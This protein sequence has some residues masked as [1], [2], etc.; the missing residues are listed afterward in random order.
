[1]SK[2]F[3]FFFVLFS[4]ELIPQSLQ[5]L[6]GVWITNV[7]SYVL[8]SDQNITEA[9]DFLASRG[10][11]VVFP[12]VW[13][14]GYTCYPSSIMDNLFQKPIDPKYIGRDPLKRLI[15]E[16]HRNGIEV[17]PWFE[18]G[19]SPN[20]AYNSKD[21]GHIIKRFPDW[22]LKDKYG[23]FAIKNYDTTGFIWMSGIN[24]AVQ[25]FMISL[26]TE[27]IDRYDIDGVQGDDRLPAM[28][29]EGGYDSTTVAIYKSEN[30]GNNPP[31]NEYDL[32]WK[33]WRA[34]KLNYFFWRLRDS[35]KSK[36]NYLLLSS[37]PSV[38]PW[39]YDNY[40]QD[41]KTWV[42][43]GIV[44]NFIP[45]LYRYNISQYT[46]ELNTALNY[47][48]ASK[49][50]IFF[51]GVLA[52]VGTYVIPVDFLLQTVALNRS[53]NV[54]GE[55]YFFYEAFRSENNKR[56]D[57][58]RARYYNQNALL[59]YRNGNLFRP[60]ATILNEDE[61]GISSI[62]NWTQI[63]AIGYRPNIL[64]ASDSNFASI[65]Y[66]M[67]IPFDAWFSVYTYLIPNFIFSANANYKLFSGI[68]SSSFIINQQLSSN[69]GWTK[70]GD[71]YLTRGLKKVMTLDNSLVEAGKYIMAD[72]TMI[73][74]NRKL[75]PNVF[76][77]DVKEDNF[78]NNLIPSK[79][80]LFQN[81][82][83]P[84]N[85]ATKIKFSIE[86][87]ENVQLKVYD[88]L[89]KEITTL[90]NDVKNPGVYVIEFEANHLSNGIYFYQLITSEKII[91]K[92]MIL[93]K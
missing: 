17:I 59:P 18:Y 86:Q 70:V 43:S 92:K 25:N 32:T 6:R 7:D 33:S 28:P 37:A 13:N 2:F 49:K 52:K 69:N 26:I 93:L 77:T 55:T 60:P 80:E 5:E 75:S 72:A 62:G 10:F 40:L 21:S 82:P 87:T 35:V 65:T 9:M 22:L 24:P 56:A 64:I 46:T 57:T 54:K 42:D 36:F 78:S 58:L 30:N 53:K 12:V 61:N 66:T 1:M 89:G 84:F 90:L 68:D 39:G 11:N 20:Y 50:N 45:Q 51:A 79:L 14:K 81:F 71:V 88:L 91:S 4:I 67:N 44:D 74:I 34:K 48:P 31:S 76:V 85:P 23:K 41:S 27:V 19:F 29:I 16:A 83:N 3:Y 15:I 73:M 38:Y 63:S 8:S 47:V